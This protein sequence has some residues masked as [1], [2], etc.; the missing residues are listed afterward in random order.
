[1][2]EVGLEMAGWKTRKFL[3][4]ALAGLFFMVGCSGVLYEKPSAD[5]GVHRVR[6]D[7]AEGWSEFDTTPRYRSQKSKDGDGYGLMLK[8][9]A[10]F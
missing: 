5:G 1:M 4:L 7:T 8:N 2:V 3:V 10:I 6:V 9:E